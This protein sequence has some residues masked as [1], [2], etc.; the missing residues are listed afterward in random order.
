MTFS[1]VQNLY[2]VSDLAIEIF[3]VLVRLL[4]FIF[5]KFNSLFQSS[6]PGWK[7]STFQSNPTLPSDLYAVPTTVLYS[8]NRIHSF[9]V[10]SADAN[11][12]A[13]PAVGL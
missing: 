11:S 13:L 5:V 8:S 1:S 7:L 9:I 3:A 6:R 10:F 2:I 12:E 4:V